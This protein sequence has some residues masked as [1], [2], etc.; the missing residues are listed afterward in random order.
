M[1][2]FKPFF[3]GVSIEIQRDPEKFGLTKDKLLQIGV[4]NQSATDPTMMTSLTG[5]QW[6]AYWETVKIIK[7]FEYE[8]ALARMQKRIKSKKR[9]QKNKG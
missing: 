8:L 2:Q 9:E 6:D 4:C 3:V 5:E 7:Q 1:P